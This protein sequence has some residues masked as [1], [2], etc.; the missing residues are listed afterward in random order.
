MRM[1]PKLLS[2]ES[3]MFRYH[4]C[5]FQNEKSKETA[6]RI[7]LYKEYDIYNCFTMEASF[8]GYFDKDRVQYEFTVEAYEQMGVNLVNS[9][10]EYVMILEE[11]ERRKQFNKVE[12]LRLKNKA[13]A[14]QLQAELE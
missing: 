6:A 1:I 3:E 8:H 12:R 2:E 4:S 14:T 7:V 10:Y 5:T 9:L 13:K 11:S